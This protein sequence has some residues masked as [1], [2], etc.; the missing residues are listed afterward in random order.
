[1]YLALPTDSVPK[2]VEGARLH[3]PLDLSFPPNHEEKEEYV[4]DVV[5]KSLAAAKRPIILVDGCAIRHRALTET[6]AF[7]EK[8]GLPT[9][10]APMGKSAVD[11]TLP[12]YGGVYAGDASHG[13]IR[14]MVQN[15]DLVLSIGAIKSDFNTAGFTY[16]TTQMRSIDFHSDHCQVR[17][18][19]YPDVRMNG[20]LKKITERLPKLSIMRPPEVTANVIPH[21]PSAGEDDEILH[22][23][24]WPRMGHWL[25]EDDIV[26]TET[27]TAG[28][29]VW[30]TR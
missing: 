23:W 26:V 21:Q 16:R 8:S 10:V 1:V 15:S 18:S 22:E 24:F 5:L 14:D 11:E 6:H 9:F 25:K 3:E 29:G 13:A 2:K 20:V 27:G 4:V 17:Y 30:E 12:N 7:V 28:M 19:T